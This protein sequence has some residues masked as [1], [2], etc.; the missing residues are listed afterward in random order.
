MKILAT[1]YMQL[2]IDVSVSFISNESI[3]D[4]AASNT[5]SFKDKIIDDSAMSDY[6]LFVENAISIIEYYGFQQLDDPEYGDH[7]ISTRLMLAHE[8]QIENND[9]P[10]VIVFRVSD[11]IQNFSESLK[12]KNRAKTNARVQKAKLPQSKRKQKYNLYQIIVNDSTFETYEEALNEIESIV[13]TWI[14]KWNID[15]DVEEIG[16]W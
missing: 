8:L 14:E 6:Q 15:I 13:Q 9:I 4:I 7:K 16:N 2:I 3:N 5:S 11:H 12:R 10:C 1:T